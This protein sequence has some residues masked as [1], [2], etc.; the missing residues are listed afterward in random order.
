MFIK[1]IDT[2][3]IALPVFVDDIVLVINDYEEITHITTM[4]EQHFRIKNLG[5]LTCFLGLEVVKNE[6][7]VHLKICL[8]ILS[9]FKV[10]ERI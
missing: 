4:L 6:T 3:T 9:S 5:D 1:H 8:Y 10:L 2:F 7:I